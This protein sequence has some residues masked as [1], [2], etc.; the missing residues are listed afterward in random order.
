MNFA[1]RLLMVAG[2]VALAGTFGALLAPKTA[3]AIVAT[4]VQVANT[5]AN[6]VPVQETRSPALSSF[7]VTSDC[8]FLGAANC[9]VS[10]FS[11]PPGQ[12][13]VVESISSLCRVDPG[14]S[15][16]LFV[17]YSGATGGLGHIVVPF[18]N[19]EALLE[20]GLTTLGNTVN[21]RAYVGSNTS[22]IAVW[23]TSV[24]QSAGFQSCSVTMSGYLVTS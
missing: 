9:T 13:A 16:A 6:P 21:S 24:R 7:T 2:A 18:N 20:S 22:I 17:T 10:F 11:I 15:A 14:T 23:V 3:H 4:L 5:S 19:T 8:Q 12:I 1:K